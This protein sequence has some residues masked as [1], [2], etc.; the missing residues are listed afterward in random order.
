[1]KMREFTKVMKSL[2]DKK[3]GRLSPEKIR[4][5]DVDILDDVVHYLVV[6]RMPIVRE[7]IS[8]N[9]SWEWLRACGYLY[10]TMGHYFRFVH[11]AEHKIRHGV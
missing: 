11:L 5:A 2:S 1:M 9:I 10:E 7:F 6:H 4:E 3:T 8:S